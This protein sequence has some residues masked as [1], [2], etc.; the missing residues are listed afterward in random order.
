[1]QE[2]FIDLLKNMKRMSEL[3]N[4]LDVYETTRRSFKKEAH[5][6]CKSSEKINRRLELRSL[7]HSSTNGCDQCNAKK[8]MKN[9]YL[10]FKATVNY[11]KLKKN[12]GINQK[13]SAVSEVVVVIYN[14]NVST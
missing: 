13:F 2:H 3:L 14:L 1:M 6:S 8:V 11:F 9:I 5:R 10:V 4:K 7:Q 12:L